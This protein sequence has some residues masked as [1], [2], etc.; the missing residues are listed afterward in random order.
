ME[1]IGWVGGAVRNGRLVMREE[2]QSWSGSRRVRVESELDCGERGRR[3][4][5]ME[6]RE[7]REEERRCCSSVEENNSSCSSGR[8]GD[9][10]G[11]DPER[12]C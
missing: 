5:R 1:W 6:D 2:R 10:D 12:W 9:G 11:D 4:R 7:E 3:G 8:G